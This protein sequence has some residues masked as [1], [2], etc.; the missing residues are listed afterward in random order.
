MNDISNKIN[1]YSVQA[2][3]GKNIQKNA[4]GTGMPDNIA[5][6]IDSLKAANSYEDISKTLAKSV[7][8]GDIEQINPITYRSGD[9]IIQDILRY[10]GEAESKFLEALTKKGISIAPEYVD[11][12]NI[13]D[14]TI[15]I[16]KI[17]GM[18]GQDLVPFSQGYGLLDNSAKSAAFQ[19]CKK[20]VQANLINQAIFTRGNGAL[21]VI[22][23]TKKVIIPSWNMLRPIEPHEKQSILN[24]CHDI[25]FKK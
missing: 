18:D 21:F 23:K 20:L 1:T 24:S 4:E 19:D 15:L 25:L 13:E 10:N 7:E 9:Y 16:T 17:E 12:I 11:S 8:N 2:H 14:Y 3:F 6:L 5:K 22:P